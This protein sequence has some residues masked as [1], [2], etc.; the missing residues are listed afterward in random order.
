[1]VVWEGV[2][3]LLHSI[4][5]DGLLKYP[6]LVD[7]K[8]MIVLDG[9]HRVEALKL[10]GCSL[11]PA[12][13]VDYDDSCVSVSS[14]RPGVV[15]TKGMVRASGLSGLPMPP[16]TSKHR[17]CFEIPRV[18]MSLDRLGCRGFGGRG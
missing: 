13:L 2:Y 15:V 8:T 7:S 4:S 5:F 3:G 10:L 6:I 9:H 18:D 14:W 11:I 16:K 17:V 12:I 1:M